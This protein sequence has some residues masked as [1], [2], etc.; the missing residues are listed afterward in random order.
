MH[1]IIMS[2]MSAIIAKAPIYLLLIGLI[3]RYSYCTWASDRCLIHQKLPDAHPTST[4]LRKGVTTSDANLQCQQSWSRLVAAPIKSNP[5]TNRLELTS[6][7]HQYITVNHNDITMKTTLLCSLISMLFIA[8]YAFVVEHNALQHRGN[9]MRLNLKQTGKSKLCMCI[10]M[11]RLFNDCP[12]T[13]FYHPKF[14]IKSHSRR[15]RQRP[16]MTLLPMKIRT[17]TMPSTDELCI[18][19]TIEGLKTRK[20][21]RITARSHMVVG[22]IVSLQ[23]LSTL[24]FASECYLVLGSLL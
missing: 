10:F 16:S 17:T 1:H 15:R 7:P 23:D 18:L 6:P 19:S 12:L 21:E 3:S 20:M 2:A 4:Q 22:I 13:W 11:C 5:R 9:K 14:Q 8:S 24:D